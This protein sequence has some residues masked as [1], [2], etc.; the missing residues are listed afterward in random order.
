[1]ASGDNVPEIEEPGTEP[2]QQQSGDGNA[3]MSKPARAPPKVFVFASPKKGKKTDSRAV[4]R[5][6]PIKAKL[7]KALAP[8]LASSYLQ[9]EMAKRFTKEYLATHGMPDSE[10]GRRPSP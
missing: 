1:M 6:H 3:D 7:R 9:G 2:G 4:G 8:Y 5:N 10:V